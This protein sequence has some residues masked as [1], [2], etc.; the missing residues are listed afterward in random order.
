[1]NDI[2]DKKIISIYPLF[3]CLEGKCENNCCRDW[4]I[5]LDDDTVCRYRELKGIKG[6]A[7]R[8]ITLRK[9]N[10]VVRFRVFN[11]RCLNLC[12]DGLCNL[13]RTGRCELMPIICRLYPRKSFLYAG[14]EE[15]VLDLSCV[16]VARIFVENRNNIEYI[17]TD[18][19]IPVFWNL[20]KADAEFTEY[21]LA[22]RE[23]IL[24]YLQCGRAA[25]R[26]ETVWSKRNVSN[27]GS[28]E[29]G[30]IAAPENTASPDS[31]L[32]S[33]MQRL[34]D[35]HGYIYKV[36]Q[37]LAKGG[38]AEAKEVVLHS[39]GCNENG[40]FGT[41]KYAVIP[42]E[43]MLEI[44]ENRLSQ[45]RQVVHHKK[46]TELCERVLQIFGSKS[47]E[48]EKLLN[49]LQEEPEASLSGLREE[50][51]EASLNSL[52]GNMPKA[53]LND[54]ITRLIDKAL[55]ESP[56]IGEVIAAYAAYQFRFR[57]MEACEDFYVLGPVVMNCYMTQLMLMVLCADYLSN[58]D[59]YVVAG[60]KSEKCHNCNSEW[61][62]Y[63]CQNHIS[64][65]ISYIECSFGHNP[66]LD[67]LIL[68]EIRELYK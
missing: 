49:G 21:L 48:S 12:G 19:D 58:S 11:N 5:A 25:E 41:A 8:L 30:S 54:K 26:K 50:E 65:I 14:H 1:M 34:A 13:Q 66:T 4:L 15:A 55:T 3:K 60:E 52:R 56:V 39:L 24:A 2:I 33:V 7:R 67:G 29:S 27:E 37:A 9:K 42:Y 47:K 64:G 22:E 36:Q 40:R 20:E 68:A 35:V 6:R 59:P 18:E 63:G 38:I 62:P 16:E 61:L 46:A 45:R 53:S 10:G 43:V 57:F 51:H 44:I 17:E 23:N 31:S 32:F 28:A